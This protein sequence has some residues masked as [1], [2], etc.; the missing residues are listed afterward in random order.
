MRKIYGRL[1]SQTPEGY[2]LITDTAFPQGGRG[3]SLHIRAPY[4]QGNR[5]R[6]ESM[7]HAHQ[8]MRYN[9]QLTSA[10][11]AAEWCIQAIQEGY[12]RLKLPLDV[13][14]NDERGD[15]I[16]IEVRMSNVCTRRVGINQT[17]QFYV[18]L[19]KE[20]EVDARKWDDF[21]SLLF[22]DVQRKDRVAN[23]HTRLVQGA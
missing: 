4:K 18:P 10:R 19:W 3:V 17:L 6:A 8:L 21:E 2:C 11:Q 23:F 22:G 16:E 15:I 13:R 12:A 5:V 7:A 1:Q 9:M 14:D 20:N